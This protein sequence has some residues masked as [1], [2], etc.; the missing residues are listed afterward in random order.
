M[1][2]EGTAATLAPELIRAEGAAVHSI[3]GAKQLRDVSL[4]EVK[5]RAHQRTHRKR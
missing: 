4:R 5:H 2:P 3:A 1:A